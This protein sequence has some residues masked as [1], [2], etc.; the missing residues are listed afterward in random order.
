MRLVVFDVDG[1]LTDGSLFF[2]PSGEVLKKFHA[3]DGLGIVL[4]RR[5]GIRYE[6]LI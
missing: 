3:R 2:G 1:V 5:A 4:L 6:D